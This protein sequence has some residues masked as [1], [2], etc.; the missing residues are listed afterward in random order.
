MFR[1]VPTHDLITQYDWIL[2]LYGCMEYGCT[3]DSRFFYLQ[4]LYFAL[5]EESIQ[6]ITIL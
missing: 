2:K 5:K 3:T 6:Q 4:L 1:H